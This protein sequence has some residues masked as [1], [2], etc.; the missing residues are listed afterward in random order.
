MCVTEQ[1]VTVWAVLLGKVYQ[2]RHI[3]MQYMYADGQLS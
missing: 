2:G 1:V 3:E